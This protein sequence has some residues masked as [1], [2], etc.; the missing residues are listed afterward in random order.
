MKKFLKAI[1]SESELKIFNVTVK[2]YA[3]YSVINIFFMYLSSKNVG[4]LNEDIASGLFL[5]WIIITFV[6]LPCI[7]FNSTK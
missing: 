5:S 7:S 2:P 4:T 3:I 1:F 6:M